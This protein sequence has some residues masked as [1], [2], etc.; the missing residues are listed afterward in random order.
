MI[1]TDMTQPLLANPA[2]QQRIAA[3]TP[4]RRVGAPE[5]IAETAAWLMSPAASFVTGSIVTVSGGR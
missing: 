5:E 2:T 1:A 3:I 4:L